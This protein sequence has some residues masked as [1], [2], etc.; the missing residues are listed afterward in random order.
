MTDDIMFVVMLRNGTHEDTRS[1]PIHTCRDKLVA[2]GIAI[3]KNRAATF[4]MGKVE[5][6][7]LLLANWCETHPHH[8]DLMIQDREFKSEQERLNVILGIDDDA[9]ALGFANEYDMD[10]PFWY[11][12]E[13]PHIKG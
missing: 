9:K 5:A 7:D 3:G 4:L 11:V 12:V 2:E 1:K 8:V 10:Q 13:V 6:R